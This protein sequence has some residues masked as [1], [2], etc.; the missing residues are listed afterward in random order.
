[1]KMKVKDNK[2][3]I[4]NLTVSKPNRFFGFLQRDGY[5]MVFSSNIWVSSQCEDLDF[6]IK[7]EIAHHYLALREKFFSRLMPISFIAIPVYL[8]MLLLHVELIWKLALLAI[9]YLLLILRYFI[10]YDW[11]F[12]KH[13]AQVDNLVPEITYE[14]IEVEK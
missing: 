5:T 14:I 12:A 8:I 1:M 10:F 3:K 2:G 4:F 6:A 9:T 13:E 11:F 7:H